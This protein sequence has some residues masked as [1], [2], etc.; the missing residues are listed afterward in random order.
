MENHNPRFQARIGAN[1]SFGSWLAAARGP[2]WGRAVPVP[3][4]GLGEV[5]AVS[6][7]NSTI[8][9]PLGELC[10]CVLGSD[11]N[12]GDE[13]RLGTSPVGKVCTR[14]HTVSL[15]YR[16][17]DYESRLALSQPATRV[18]YIRNLM[19]GTGN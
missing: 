11:S 6:N 3:P 12:V 8:A 1:N 9:T 7:P 13:R 19:A 4:G 16:V 5:V 17:I 14:E 18:R 15:D 2:D 10:G